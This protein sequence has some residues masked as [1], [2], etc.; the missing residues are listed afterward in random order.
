[1]LPIALRSPF[2]K[3]LDALL[4]SFSSVQPTS[5]S[6]TSPGSSKTLQRSV[7]QGHSGLQTPSSYHNVV[8]RE[9][10]I[11]ARAKCDDTIPGYELDW[12]RRVVMKMGHFLSDTA[13]TRDDFGYEWQKC[14]FNWKRAREGSN[15]SK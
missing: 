1:M 14:E 5:F 15:V 7:Q 11:D 10:H 4:I 12:L 3:F 9:K 2:H 13:Q 6:G 8:P